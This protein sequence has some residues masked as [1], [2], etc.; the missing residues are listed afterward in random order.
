M[1]TQKSI[2]K[3]I[4]NSK[5]NFNNMKDNKLKVDVITK[6]EK[7]NIIKW[8]IISLVGLNLAY[9]FVV[10]QVFDYYGFRCEF[11][12]YKFIFGVLVLAVSICIGYKINKPF[13]YA[14][15]NIMFLYLLGGEVVYYQ[16][17]PNANL[18]QILVI[19]ICLIFIYL[20][21][22]LNIKFKEPPVIKNIDFV[23]G[24][25]TVLMFAPFVVLFYKYIN[26][27]NL[28]FID[29]Y[30]TRAVFSNLN[31]IYAAYMKAPLARVLLPVLIVK[32]RN[33]KQYIIMSLYILMLIYL[34]LCGALKSIFIGLIAIIIFYNGTYSQKTLRFIKGV[35]FLTYAGTITYFLFDSV[36]LLDALGRRVF[37]VPAQLGNVYYDFF[38]DNFTFLSHSPFGLGIVQYPYD[39]P[40][41]KYVGEFVIGKPGLSANVGIFTEGIISFGFLGGVVGALIA[42]LIVLYFGMIKIDKRYF[43]IIFVYIYYINTSLL[44]TL[45]LTHGLFFL[46]VFAYLFLRE[47]GVKKR[48]AQ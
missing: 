19:F 22:K 48:Q 14:V 44:S 17:N 30:K 24:L 23:I 20:F 32:Q 5:T 11:Y 26:L 34:Y 27:K 28:L 1:C 36:F 15:W 39:R 43:G 9:I 46:M 16:Y 25:I 35:A 10:S 2:H 38:K 31:N 7:I 47:E 40:I 45:L 13:F 18:I 12:L 41:V 42:S 29:V 6:K 33:K 8:Q 21:S 3:T 37:F 4:N